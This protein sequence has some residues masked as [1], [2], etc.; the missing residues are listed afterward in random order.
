MSKP[1]C[2]LH[3][4][5]VVLIMSVWVFRIP[6][7]ESISMFLFFSTYIVDVVKEKRIARFRWSREKWLYVAFILLFLIA[8]LWQLFTGSFA[9]HYYNRFMSN[10][11]YFLMAGI[12]GMLGLSEKVKTKY[13]AYSMAA[14]S[15]FMI[16]FILF[17][18]DWPY[19]FSQAAKRWVIAE[20]RVKYFT[21]HLVFNM[22]LNTTLVFI[23]HTLKKDAH[24]KWS[25]WFLTA[26]AAIIVLAECT[27][28]GR[29]GLAVMAVILAIF[30]FSRIKRKSFQVVIAACIALI[31][32]GFLLLRH[33]QSAIIKDENS[34][35]AL[36]LQ[37]DRLFTPDSTDSN[38]TAIW[39]VGMHVIQ[40]K[41]LLG[42][43]ISGARVA[44]VDKGFT[45]RDFMEKYYEPL[46]LAAR[47]DPKHKY[48]AHVH[49]SFLDIWMQHGILG[50]L[51]LIFVF[52][53]PVII[54]P[55]KNR[56]SVIMLVIVFGSQA[57]V[58]IIG[59]A[60]ITQALAFG[61]L[62]LLCDTTS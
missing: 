57:L 18:M 20:V 17:K 42:Y 38:R 54:S 12:V 21:D 39:R 47:P 26:S 48:G 35:F 41:P 56:L 28:E 30:L 58:D 22:Y 25:K 14:V 52:I 4:L 45:D 44:Y 32:G 15:L 36:F 1:V 51:L 49:N 23:F 43:G 53:W 46:Y 62:L 10:R 60:V 2:I 61:L 29:T 50:V 31:C 34:R 9:E 24:G 6:A 7:L 33:G 8:P 11:L 19:F 55:P 40:E 3:I 5:G 16:L 37:H 27:S 59:G 13:I